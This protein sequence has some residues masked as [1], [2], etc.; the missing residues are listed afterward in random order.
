[1]RI[2]P[3]SMNN[4]RKLWQIEFLEIKKVTE[5]KNIMGCLNGTLDTAEENIGEQ[6]VRQKLPWCFTKR[7]RK[8]YKSKVKKHRG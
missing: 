4:I 7:Q 3:A 2:E 6:K 1:M 8:K 5:I